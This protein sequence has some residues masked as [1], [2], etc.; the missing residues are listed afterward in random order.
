MGSLLYIFL[1][2]ELIFG[3]KKGRK[4]FKNNNEMATVQ[5]QAN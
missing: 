1:A 5:N 4:L 2:T 3:S